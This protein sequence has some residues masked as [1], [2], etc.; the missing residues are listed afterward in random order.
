[1]A[2]GRDRRGVRRP[3]WAE[4]LEA[5]GAEIDGPLE[6]IEE[7]WTRTGGLTALVVGLTGATARPVSGPA[8]QDP[9]R[10]A[11]RVYAESPSS[12]DVRITKVRHVRH[13]WYDDLFRGLVER[14]AAWR[15]PPAPGPAARTRPRRCAGRSTTSRWRSNSGSGRSGGPTG[16]PD[17]PVAAASTTSPGWTTA[18]HGRVGGRAARRRTRLRALGPA[19]SAAPRPLPLRRRRRAP[20]GGGRA[21]R[22][23]PTSGPCRAT[24][25]PSAGGSARPPHAR[26]PTWRRTSGR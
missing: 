20:R 12:A 17:R 15:R 21:P 4:H 7:E 5:T 14:N 24:G 2:R 13:A 1:M 23:G 18:A 9:E 22:P 19:R 16:S 11:R 25:R 6:R 3:A 8:A 10:L 26:S